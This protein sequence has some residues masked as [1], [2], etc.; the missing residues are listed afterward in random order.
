MG[1]TDN[2][3]LA[4]EIKKG[5]KG[6]LKKLYNRYHKQL[7]FVAKRYL[8]NEELAEDA[9]QDVFLK[10][11]D[12]RE[13]LDQERS[14]EGFLFTVLKN[15]V[16]N[17]VRD[18][19]TRQKML[20]EIRQANTAKESSHAADERVIYSEYKNLLDRA[21]NKLSPAKKEVFKLRSRQGL[22]NK[23]IADRRGV[24]KHTIK[25]QYYLGSKYV[26]NYLKKHAGLF[27]FILMLLQL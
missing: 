18:E 15:H 13:R 19:K 8:K 4:S 27:I 16:L 17:M 2:A 5:G 3:T 7:Y 1:E 21:I 20:D 14:I 23:E 10:V 6:A 11:W 26:R 24:S 9:V 22:T 25:T 12:K